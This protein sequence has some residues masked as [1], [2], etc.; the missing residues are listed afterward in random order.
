MQF[1]VTVKKSAYGCGKYSFALTENRLRVFQNDVLKRKFV[2][3]QWKVNRGMEK[4]YEDHKFIF[5]RTLL[6][7]SNQGS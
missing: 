5:H 1:V 7:Y 6:R 2:P 3:K 4:L